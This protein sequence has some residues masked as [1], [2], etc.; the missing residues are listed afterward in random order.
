MK[1]N[2]ALM[3]Y[4]VIQKILRISGYVISITSVYHQGGTSLQRETVRQNPEVIP[5]VAF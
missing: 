4:Q 2:V 1:S 5:S 3:T